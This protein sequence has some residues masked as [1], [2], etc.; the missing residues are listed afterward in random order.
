MLPFFDITCLEAKKVDKATLWKD[1]KSLWSRNKNVHRICLAQCLLLGFPQVNRASLFPWPAYAS[2][3]SSKN[4]PSHIGRT[5]IRTSPLPNCGK[6]EASYWYRTVPKQ[7][8]SISTPLTVNSSAW[9]IQEAEN[10]L[11]SRLFGAGPTENWGLFTDT[12]RGRKD[13]ISFFFVRN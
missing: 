9:H 10:G 3:C 6:D 7:Q 12:G 5:V 8:L 11:F 1:S 13:L 2:I 4:P